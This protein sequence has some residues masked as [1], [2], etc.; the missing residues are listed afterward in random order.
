MIEIIAFD[1]DDTLWENESF[2]T[3][4]K[5]RFVEL[6]SKY[7]SPEMVEQ[8]L[9]EIE[10]SNI[11]YYGYGIKSFILSMIETAIDLSDGR[12]DGWE[13]QLIIGLAKEVLTAEVN[14][15]EHAEDTVIKLAKR[16]DLMLITKG[17]QWEQERKIRR[18][19]LAKYFRYV[20]IVGDKTQEAYHSIL[21]KYQIEPAGFLMV[22]NSIKSDILPVL[23]IGG[24]AVYIP[25]ENTWFH[26]LEIGGAA[27]LAYDELA[28]L[29]LLPDY[30]ERVA[31]RID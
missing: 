16:F 31:N 13:I 1:A 7:Q 27:H 22:G 25:Y 3:R 26:E 14:L 30:I 19:G 9:N 6:V 21:A 8:R 29:G 10:I 12:V 11:R 2:Y 20:E 24:Q 23:A 5:S 17:E 4:A 15:F 28:H 18:S